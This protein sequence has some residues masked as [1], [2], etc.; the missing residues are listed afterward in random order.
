MKKVN[1][2]NTIALR[3][4]FDAVAPMNTPSQR[5]AANP[6][7]GMRTVQVIKDLV[8]S[9]TSLSLVSMLRIWLGKNIYMIAENALITNPQKNSLFSMFLSSSGF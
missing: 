2:E 7:M 9:I 5:N 8:T 1:E 6:V 3:I 4:S